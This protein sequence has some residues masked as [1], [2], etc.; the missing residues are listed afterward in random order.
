MSANQ[1]IDDADG[2]VRRQQCIDNVA[3]DEPGTAGDDR[4]GLPTHAAFNRLSSRT[5]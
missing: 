1:V 5:L 2:K 4:S 3:A